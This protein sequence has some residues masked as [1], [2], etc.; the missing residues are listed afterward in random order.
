MNFFPSRES[1]ERRTC[2]GWYRS[3]DTVVITAAILDNRVKSAEIY[4]CWPLCIRDSCSV[5]NEE[6]N[7]RRAHDQIHYARIFCAARG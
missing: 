4:G 5:K 6:K 3:L 1:E 7:R 2:G